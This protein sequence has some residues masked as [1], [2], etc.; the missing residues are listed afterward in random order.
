VFL[1]N[2]LTGIFL[3]AAVCCIAFLPAG[4]R[5]FVIDASAAVVALLWIFRVG[6]GIRAWTGTPG[7]SLYYLI[8]YLCAFELAP[9]FVIFK[10]A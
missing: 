1:V 7:Y 9:L 6:R 10:L 4:L 8:L 3:L 2:N 5:L